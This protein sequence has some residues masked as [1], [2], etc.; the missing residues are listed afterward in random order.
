MDKYYYLVAQLPFL[1]FN[2]GTYLNK[3]SFLE[4][5]KKWLSIRAFLIL[6]SVDI[7]DFDAKPQDIETLREYKNFERT[8]REELVL[9]R[10]SSQAA[11]NNFFIYIKGDYLE[12]NPL[13]VEKNLLHLRWEFIEQRQ[14]DHYFDLDFL[15]FYFLKLQIIERLLT[16]DKEEGTKIFDSLCEVTA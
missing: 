15:V 4:E 7:D 13:E 2:E 9:I 5:A 6:S 3:S 10:R 14:K 8:L 1:K 12:G 16:F 11:A